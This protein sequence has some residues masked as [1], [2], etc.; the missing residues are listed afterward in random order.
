LKSFVADLNNFQDY[1]L[2]LLPEKVLFIYFGGNSLV[3]G[4][5]VDVFGGFTFTVSTVD[6]DGL[7]PVLLSSLSRASSDELP[8]E[9]PFVPRLPGAF[10]LTGRGRSLPLMKK[11]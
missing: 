9:A 11:F 1:C 7:S 6:E 8:C 4:S 3:C 2:L 10:L 5:I